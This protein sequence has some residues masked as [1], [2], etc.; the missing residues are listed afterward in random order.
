MELQQGCC[1]KSTPKMDDPNFK[2]AIVLITELNANGAVGFIL[3]KSFERKLNE[4]VEFSSSQPFPLYTG[5]PVDGE[6]LYFI[7]QQPSLISDGQLIADGLYVGGNFKEAVEAI[8]ADLLSTDDI[9][10]FVGYCGW[11]AGEL[12]TEIAEGSWEVIATAT[13]KL[14]C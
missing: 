12:E 2:D 8:D 10:I 1:I 14:F 9:K 6:H 11:D 4:L 5:G 3:N 13:K 7:H